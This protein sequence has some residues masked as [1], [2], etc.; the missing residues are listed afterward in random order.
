MCKS[1]ALRSRHNIITSSLNFYGQDAICDA[2]LTVSRQMSTSHNKCW[3]W[4]HMWAEV[5]TW[6]CDLTHLMYTKVSS[7]I[8]HALGT[9]AVLQYGNIRKAALLSIWHITVYQSHW[10]NKVSIFVWLPNIN[11]QS[12][13]PSAKDVCGC[14]TLKV[15]F[16][17]TLF[18]ITHLK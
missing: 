16:H 11:W 17:I 1:F 12:C 10:L 3:T 8:W 9:N 13:R 4:Q 7:L 5:Q 6:L 18:Y 2:Q 14:S 15:K